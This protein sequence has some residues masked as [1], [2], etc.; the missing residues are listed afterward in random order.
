MRDRD[1]VR[2][3]FSQGEK[4]MRPPRGNRFSDAEEAETAP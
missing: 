1:A 3:I 2:K 4:N